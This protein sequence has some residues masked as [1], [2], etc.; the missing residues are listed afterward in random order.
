[1]STVILKWNPSFSSHSMFHHLYNIRVMNLEPQNAE[2]NWSVCD[3]E[4][5]HKGDTYYFVKV[6]MF[7]QIGIVGKG[8]IISEPYEAEDWS[9]RGRRTFYIDYKPDYLLNPDVMKILDAKTLA[10]NI[11]DFE[12][13]RGH[14]GV[15]LNDEQ[16]QKLE[17]LW[18]KFIAE[19]EEEMQRLSKKNIDYD[20]VYINKDE[21][22]MVFVD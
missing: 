8:I 1:M 5:I 12:W 11:P 18:N 15:V 19:N 9:G 22:C 14:S 7:G 10:E 17:E 3:Y 4:K 13:D 20:L 2:F 21:Y 6:G 16:A